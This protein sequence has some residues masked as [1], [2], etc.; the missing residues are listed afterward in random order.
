MR[1]CGVMLSFGR[2]ELCEAIALW[3]RQTTQLPLLVYL[4]HHTPRISFRDLPK[5]V[6]VVKGPKVEARGIGPARNLAIQKARELFRLSSHD[7]V[8]M[9]DDDDYYSPHHV[10]HTLRVLS[11]GAR[12]TGARRIG[13]S[14]PG[15]PVELVESMDGPGQHAAWGME[16]G[17]WEEHGGYPDGPNED[18]QLAI[19]IG[20]HRCS[21][22]YRLTHVRIVHAGNLSA[23]EALKHA[24]AMARARASATFVD[25][26]RPE[27]TA[28]AALLDQWCARTERFLHS[29][30]G[31][32]NAGFVRY[33]GTL[34]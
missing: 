2:V 32:Y 31:G 20:W 18:T 14:Q 4:D 6:A 10:E 22:H 33:H 5:N 7:A 19:A 21:P 25:V 9:L 27:L 13:L 30:L 34:T 8:L 29:E 3:A 11:S 15:L 12:W 24:D 1:A 26:V 28:R 17:L 16:L 23:F